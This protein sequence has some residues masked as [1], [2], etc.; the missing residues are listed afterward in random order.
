M[1][2]ME[3]F[4]K[5][6]LKF[7]RNRWL[8]EKVERKYLQLLRA[9]GNQKRVKKLSRE[10]LILLNKL[11]KTDMYLYMEEDTNKLR[12]NAVQ[13]MKK[14]KENKLKFAFVAFMLAV[15]GTFNFIPIVLFFRY[16]KY[17]KRNNK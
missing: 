7:R 5:F 15:P 10:F 2:F 4:R 1:G 16:L 8:I 17:R 6:K 12:E 13:I 11:K 3:K 14:P 9:I